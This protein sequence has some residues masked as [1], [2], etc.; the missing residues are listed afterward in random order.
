MPESLS[1][2]KLK[3]KCRLLLL[4]PKITVLW[5]KYNNAV[6]NLVMNGFG[7]EI[8]I[9]FIIHSLKIQRA[10][11]SRQYALTVKFTTAVEHR[12]CMNHGST[13]L[14]TEK[15]WRNNF[16]IKN[17]SVLFGSNLKAGFRRLILSDPRMNE[18]WRFMRHNIQMYSWINVINAK[19]LYFHYNYC[20]PWFADIS[21]YFRFGSWAKTLRRL[22][23]ND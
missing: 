6:F 2:F 12:G 7:A 18:N 16:R 20:R 11:S 4:L 5:M 10:S 15:N 19:K 8:S 22:E 9:D 3:H 1:I 21:R 23:P 17:L 14:C 13:V